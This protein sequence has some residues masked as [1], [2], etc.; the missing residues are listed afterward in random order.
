MSCTS[1]FL[2]DLHAVVEVTTFICLVFQYQIIQS[3]QHGTVHCNTTQY[4]DYNTLKYKY[5]KL[6]SKFPALNVAFFLKTRNYSTFA[7]HKCLG[8]DGGYH[9]ETPSPRDFQ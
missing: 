5:K 2:C 7:K 8:R 4:I 6:Q 3:F 9:F 1:L